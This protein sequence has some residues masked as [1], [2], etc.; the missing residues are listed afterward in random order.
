MPYLFR[1]C[2]S[3]GE[4]PRRPGAREGGGND[5]P[6][7]LQRGSV[8]NGEGG[9]REDDGH[10]LGGDGEVRATTR[11]PG[12]HNN[13]RSTLSERRMKKMIPHGSTLR[14]CRKQK[15]APK[16]HRGGHSSTTQTRWRDAPKA[17]NILI[18]RAFQRQRRG[19]IH[20]GSSL[21]P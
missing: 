4:R 5:A 16:R 9:G 18:V 20:R 11:S 13:E 10:E 8:V 15:N 1:D 17:T 3:Q 12:E 7:R 6:G 2:G 14:K 21:R 19:A